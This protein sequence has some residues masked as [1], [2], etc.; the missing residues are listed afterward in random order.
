MAVWTRRLLVGAVVVLATVSAGC[1]LA[2]LGYFLAP[3]QRTPPELMNL[4]VPEKSQKDS[5]VLILTWSG[6]EM[7]TELIHADRELS[8]MLSKQLVDLAKQ[9]AEKLTVIPSRKIEEYKSTHP[10]WRAIDQAQIG[11]HFDADWVIYL[12]LN[13]L[14]LYEPQSAGQ[15][16]RGRAQMTVSLVD[17]HHPDDSPQQ[18]AFSTT[19]PSE[20]RGP[21]PADLDT[22][23]MAFRQ[24]FMQHV[25]KSL[26]TYFVHYPKRETYFT[27]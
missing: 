17:V 21:V 26:A 1:D 18:K 24:N 7:R 14:T 13:S 25:A 23:P 22:N 16:F 19:Y 27:E 3:E 4:A 15:L 10:N 8:T 20:A 6:L 2:T 12:E 11:R 5:R 9:N